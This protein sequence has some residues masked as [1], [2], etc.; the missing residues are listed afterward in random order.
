[1]DKW[2]SSRPDKDWIQ[3]AV[4]DGAKGPLLIE[5]MTRRV[6]ART[7]KGGPGHEEV[8]V[9]I[10]YKDRDDQQVVKT[11]YY[12]SN[13]SADTKLAEFGRVAKAEH[14]IEECIQRAKSEAGLADYQVRNWKGWHH[15][16]TLSLIASWFLV[17]EGLRGKKMDTGDHSSPNPRRHFLDPSPGVRMRYTLS[18]LERNASGV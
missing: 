15:H 3:V 10:R 7:D 5:M 16:Q 17:T 13:A 6:V 9:V 11:D 12:L 2:A 18:G 1:M 14:R 4:R 8:L